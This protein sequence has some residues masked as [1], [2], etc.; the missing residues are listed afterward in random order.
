VLRCSVEIDT[1]SVVPHWLA[2]LLSAMRD[3]AN[4]TNPRCR[5]LPKLRYWTLRVAKARRP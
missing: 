2:F 3:L 5:M 1:H 4:P